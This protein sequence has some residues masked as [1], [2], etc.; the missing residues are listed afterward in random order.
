MQTL[1]SFFYVLFILFLGKLGF[2][3]DPKLSNISLCVSAHTDEIVKDIGNFQNS[4]ATIEQDS[5]KAYAMPTLLKSPTSE[6]VLTWSEKDQAGVNS[7]Y[8][9]TSK[10]KGKTFSDK[11]L[12]ASGSGL[13]NNKM[14]RAKLAFKK[15][16]SVIAIFASKDSDAGNGSKGGKGA[17]QI[18]F[19]NSKDSGNTWSIPVAVD[20]DPTPNLVRGF[21][22]AAVLPNDEVAIVYLKDVAGSTKHEERNLRMVLSEKGQFLPERIIDAVVCD[23]CPVNMLVDAAGYL[24]VNYRD[25]N[26]D[27]RD[28]ATMV[29]KDNGRTFSDPKIITKDGWKIAGCPHAGAASV[30]QG[31]NALFAWTSGAEKEPGLRLSN[32]EGKRLFINAEA[33]AKNPALIAAG[34]SNFMLW[35]ENQGE[36]KLS[37]IAYKSIKNSTVSDTKWLKQSENATNVSALTLESNSVLVAY[38]IK[39]TS[40]RNALKVDLV[41]L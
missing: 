15:D 36:S 5:M 2:V 31:K 20:I 9:A 35:E 40:K 13:A 10:D 7:F 26:D 39:K 17:L 4:Y 16:G 23:C 25:N 27:I 3:A 30:V 38:E 29:S 28:I 11:K 37:K 6:V 41:T 34:A 14:M 24:H 18:M 12:I 8:F 32:S 1:T 21:F 33:S 22:D 19:T